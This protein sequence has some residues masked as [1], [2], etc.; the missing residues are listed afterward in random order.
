MEEFKW[1]KEGNEKMYCDIGKMTGKKNP[2]TTT[3]CNNYF[4]RNLK[5]FR[6]WNLFW[7]NVL[8]IT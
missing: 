3:G 7:P 8:K 5:L 4:T 2:F 1:L 6:R